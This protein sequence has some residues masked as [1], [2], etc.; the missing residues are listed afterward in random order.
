MK[1]NPLSEKIDKIYQIF[2]KEP[3]RKI[4]KST[5]NEFVNDHLIWIPVIV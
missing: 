5:K 3:T 1:K 2:S 4:S